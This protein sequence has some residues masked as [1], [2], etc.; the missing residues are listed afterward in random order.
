MLQHL[1]R[2]SSQTIIFGIGDA[3]TRVVALV[4]L[5]IYTHILTTAE[6]GKLAIITLVSTIALLVLDSGLGT[7][8][9]RFYFQ[10]KTPPERRKLTGTILIYLLLAAAVILLPLILLFD[11]I[12][13]LFITDASL[14]SL[15]RV[16]LIGTLFDISSVIPF[17]I[18]RAEHRAKRYATL[19]FIR[20]FVSATLN[21]IAVVVLRKGALGVVYANL[22]TSILF[23]I[24]CLVQTIRA[25]EWT[26]DLKLL[27][28]LLIFGLPLIPS[29][30][31]AWAL[32]LSD[33]IFLQKYAGFSELGVYAVSYSIAGLLNMVIGWFNTAYAPYCYSIADQADARVVYARLFT[34]ALALFSF[35]GLCLSVFAREA[36]MVLTTP[37]YYSAARIVP[38]IVLSYLFLEI[39]YLLSFGLDLTGK[40]GYGPFII[41]TGAIINLILNY[42]LIPLYGMTGAALATVLSYMTLPLIQYPIVRRLYFVS[43]EWRRLSKLALASV[44]IYLIAF[45]LKTNLIWVNLVAGMLLIILWLLVLYWWKFFTQNELSAAQSMGSRLL[46][47]FRAYFA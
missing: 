21:I 1:R 16:A 32:N 20:F 19:S 43:Y 12:A 45:V 40:T 8:F 6:Y 11:W 13:P 7:A 27:R 33:R 25:I 4:L 10:M 42:T 26:L 22:V 44:G 18:F 9:F 17:A 46:G 2:L 29:H 3:M 30:L 5:P 37:A 35:F 47:T 15:I 36:L 31:A 24:I 14:G 23:F 38:L 28:R 39:N 41:G 34:Y